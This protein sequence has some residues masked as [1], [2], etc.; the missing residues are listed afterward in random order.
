MTL[1]AL[2]LVQ[3]DINRLMGQHTT[4]LKL[5]F[6]YSKIERGQVLIY[7][8]LPCNTLLHCRHAVWLSTW[9]CSTMLSMYDT[10]IL[11]FMVV[12]NKT[13][14]FYL[15]CLLVLTFFLKVPH[16]FLFIQSS[17]ILKHHGSQRQDRV[18]WVSALCVKHINHSIWSVRAITFLLPEDWIKP[19]ITLR[20]GVRSSHL[21]TYL[22][23]NRTSSWCADRG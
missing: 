19:W 20:M 5:V 13:H 11:P 16:F 2:Q 21:Y 22:E 3:K 7:L 18:L 1:H 10:T 4:T 8:F 17:G 15:D 14:F 12:E 6:Q 23:V 9:F